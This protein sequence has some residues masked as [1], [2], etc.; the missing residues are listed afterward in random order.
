MLDEMPA[1][2]GIFDSDLE[3]LMRFK[4]GDP[5]MTRGAIAETLRVVQWYVPVIEIHLRRAATALA[6]EAAGQQGTTPRA[7]DGH[8]K[9]VLLALDRSL[10][11]WVQLREHFVGDF[12]DE[13]LDLLLAGERL[14]RAVEERFPSARTFRRPELD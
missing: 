11:A 10:P 7:S 14:R 1:A 5:G 12:G 8:A 2:V 13:L 3:E 4:I 6:E 9:V